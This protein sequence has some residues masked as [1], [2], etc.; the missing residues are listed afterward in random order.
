MDFLVLI[1]KTVEDVNK[2]LCRE[3]CLDWANLSNTRRRMDWLEI[4]GLIDCVG[5]RKWGLTEEGRQALK[6]WEL[7]APEIVN[8][9]SCETKEIVIVPPPAEI[10][11]LLGKLYST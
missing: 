11:E 2:E 8:T 9:D 10:Q 4:L 7:V 5:N 1:P 3:Y 6:K